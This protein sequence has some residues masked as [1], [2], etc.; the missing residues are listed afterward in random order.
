MFPCVWVGLVLAPLSTRSLWH[1][2]VKAP[3]HQY[4]NVLP[5]CYSLI[6]CNACDTGGKEAQAIWHKF[7]RPLYCNCP[8][9]TGPHGTHGWSPCEHYA[10]KLCFCHL[11]PAVTPPSLRTAL[12]H[13]GR[14][15]FI[16][17]AAALR[18]IPLLLSVSSLLPWCGSQC[19]SQRRPNGAALI[20]GVF[21]TLD[22]R[23]HLSLPLFF[24]RLGIGG[25]QNP[26]FLFFSRRERAAVLGNSVK[27]CAAPRTCGHLAHMFWRS[28]LCPLRP[29]GPSTCKGSQGC[30]RTETRSGWCSY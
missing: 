5:P 12:F 20:P 7:F 1:Q 24:S 30:F 15:K 27:R 3:W 21:P 16:W 9:S 26:S 28:A 2:L 14:G 29:F 22:A 8:A 13:E 6:Q 19:W 10:T 4:H 23:R 11:F 18:H 17:T 25:S